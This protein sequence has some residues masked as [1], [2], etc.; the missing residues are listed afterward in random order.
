M[1]EPMGLEPT[2]FSL[3]GNCAP[4]C[5]TAP[6]KMVATVALRGTLRYQEDLIGGQGGCRAHYLIENGFT[7]RR[8]CRF[9]TY[10]DMRVRL[11][12]LAYPSL[13][14]LDQLVRNKMS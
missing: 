9:A 4:N 8:V 6:Y 7:V 5:A 12:I 11:F 1:V 2:T 14:R 10:P 13:Y 3:Q